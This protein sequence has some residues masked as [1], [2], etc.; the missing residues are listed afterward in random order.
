[1]CAAPLAASQLA[2]GV[3]LLVQHGDIGMASP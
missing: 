2:K 1:M 3:A